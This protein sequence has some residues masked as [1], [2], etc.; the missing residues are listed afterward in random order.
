MIQYSLNL[1]QI[2]ELQKSSLARLI[3]E[4][5]NP[6]HLARM[7]GLPVS[8][9]HGWSQRERIS[10]EGATLVEQCPNLSLTAKELRPD[11]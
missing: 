8:T 1:K 5:G 3:E 2:A 6:S 10:K 7:L 11:L 4:A 9:V